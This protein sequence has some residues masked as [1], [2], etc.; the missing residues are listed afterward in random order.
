MDDK[1]I[2]TKKEE[3]KTEIL[4]KRIED[5][6]NQLKRAVADYRNLE[7]RFEDEKKEVIKFANKDLLLKLFSAF[8]SLF[9]AERYV[10]DE[11]LKLSIKKLNDVFSDIGVKR[12]K[13]I[14]EMFDP[15]FMECVDVVEGEE[16]K[17]KEEVR[18]GFTLFD[19]VLR[20]AH[21]RVGK[22]KEEIDE[23][24]ENLVKEELQKGDYV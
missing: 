20:P 13:T 22:K 18:P 21:V 4:E 7:K 15:S 5:L 14:D 19:K 2:K 6:E 3:K 9:L 12:I 8:D 10:E 24:E 23:N 1:K 17:V 16:N 11:G